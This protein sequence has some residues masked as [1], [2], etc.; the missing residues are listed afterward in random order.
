MAIA[1]HDDAVAGTT[2]AVASCHDGWTFPEGEQE[3]SERGNNGCLAAAS[4]REV[5]NADNGLLEPT[6]AI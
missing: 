2:P 6:R 5:T 4:N 1:D 3:A